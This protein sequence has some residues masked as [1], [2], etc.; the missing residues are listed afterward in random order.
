MGKEVWKNVGALVGAALFI[1]V[2]SA[3]AIWAMVGWLGLSYGDSARLF[4]AVGAVA[5]IFVGGMFAYWRLQIFRTFEPHL[6]ISHEISHRFVGDSYVHIAVTA[7][8]HNSSRV[9]IELRKALFSLQMIAPLTN[10]EIERLFEE[11]FVKRENKDI[12]WTTLAEIQREWI[13]N[14][15]IIEPSESHQETCEFIVSSGVE[16]AVIYTYFHN[17]TSSP[18]TQSADGWSATTVHD[19]I[20]R[21]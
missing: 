10:A 3:L 6:T 17:P 9:K 12:Q 14:E 2:L 11:S 8:L 21:D 19:I 20:S 7:N 13:E 15:L 16:S 4:Q 1:V 18:N 5:V